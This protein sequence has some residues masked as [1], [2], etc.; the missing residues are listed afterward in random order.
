[1]AQRGEPSACRKVANRRLILVIVAAAL[2]PVALT[3]ITLTAPISELR[4]SVRNAEETDIVN[5]QV[6]IDDSRTES[7]YICPGDA[8]GVKFHVSPGIH[9]VYIPLVMFSSYLE[10]PPDQYFD[11]EFTVKVGFNSVHIERLVV[12]K[13]GIGEYEGD[14]RDTMREPP[15]PPTSPLEQAVRDPYFVIPAVVLTALLGLLVATIWDYCDAPPR[16]RP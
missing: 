11:Y 13:D 12:D 3:V 5:I 1:L 16:K 7:R 8:V 14:V 2:L 9:R 4:V 6:C 15:H 10:N